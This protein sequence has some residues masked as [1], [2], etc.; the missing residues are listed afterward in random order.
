VWG[1]YCSG[2]N[3]RWGGGLGLLVGGGGGGGDALI[4]GVLTLS[5]FI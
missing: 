5:L 2:F 4:S 1:P 3:G